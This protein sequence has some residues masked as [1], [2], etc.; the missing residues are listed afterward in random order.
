MVAEPNVESISLAER[1]TPLLRMTGIPGQWAMQLLALDYRHLLDASV[2]DKPE[3]ASV[4]RP[5]PIQVPTPWMDYFD[6]IPR[7]GYHPKIPAALA[8]S[9]AAAK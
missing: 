9:K 2:L 1:G 4:P 6:E 3:L 5:E 8:L 7:T